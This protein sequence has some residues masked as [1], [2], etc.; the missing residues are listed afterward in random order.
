ML[1]IS[2][3]APGTGD[4]ARSDIAGVAARAFDLLTADAG[5]SEVRTTRLLNALLV[6]RDKAGPACFATAL[7]ALDKDTRAEVERHL[8]KRA[9]P[10]VHLQP[11]ARRPGTAEADFSSA[12][13]RAALAAGAAAAA[14]AL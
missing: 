13:S 8:S 1:A 7:K 5:R 10:V 2:A 14:E 6:L 3:H 12:D 9:V 11:A 4:A